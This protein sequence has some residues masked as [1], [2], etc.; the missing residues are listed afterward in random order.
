[1]AKTQTNDDAPALSHP[2]ETFRLFGLEAAET[3]VLDALESGRMHHAWLLTGSRGIGKATLAYRATRRALGAQPEPSLGILGAHPDDPVCRRIAA[4]GHSDVLALER[5]LD[6][7]GG[8]KA[9]IPVE[10]ARALGAFFARTSGEGGRRICIIDA[11]DEMTVQAANAIL[12]TLEEPP[13]NSLFFLIAH[14]PGQLPATIASRCRR[15]PIRAPGVEAATKA[16]EVHTGENIAKVKA[17]AEASGGRPGEAMRLHLAGGAKL[18]Q[19]L[20]SVLLNGDRRASGALIDALAAR[21]ADADRTAFFAMTR[22]HLSQAAKQEEGDRAE[23]IH[24]AWA[25]LAML[26]ADL[27]RLRMDPKLVI[28][29]AL[30]RIRRAS[31]MN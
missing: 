30:R 10:R 13:P 24:D 21:A 16:L 20:A 2:R 25:A 26:E 3:T 11:A 1:M 4:Q 19:Q 31:E 23:R 27:V 8:R 12:K 29:A 6:D 9:E 15:L 28:G 5:P 22:H 7:R 14:A 17:A 18:A